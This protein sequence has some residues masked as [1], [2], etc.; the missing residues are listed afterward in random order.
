MVR[1][2]AGML[3]FALLVVPS[4]S[5]A[6]PS[7]RAEIEAFF[8]R[9]KGIL[10]DATDIREARAEF[11]SLTHTLFDGRAAARQALGP[12]WDRS[13][14]AARSE[15]SRVF[16]DVFERAYL[17]IVQGQL[18]R[19]KAPSIRVIGADMSGERQAV[20]RTSV[21]AKDGRDV[22]MNYAMARTGER[23]QVHDVVIDG[24][25]LVENYRAQFAR[26]LQTAPY[27]ELL[28]RLRAAAGPDAPSLAA[29]EAD[30]PA[31]AVVYF[32][33]NRAD[34]TADARRELEKVAPKLAANGSAHVVVEGHA[35]GRGDS[36]SN[37]A[38]AARRAQAIREHLV[39]SGVDAGRIAIATYGDRRPV[40]QDQAESC[41]AQN[42][43]ASVR[44]TP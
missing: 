8:E 35:D 15:F 14:P 2:A 43:R 11:R 36:R 4:V 44:W 7:P 18:P 33:A 39:E 31:Q 42:R 19:D 5:S 17:E 32:R 6:A 21:R 13:T 37:E 1:R 9:A 3:L 26:V 28:E 10:G 27:S 22:P 38:L 29:T 30:A 34:L 40:C 41:W 25:S 16:G 12:E 24:V 20:V 23:W